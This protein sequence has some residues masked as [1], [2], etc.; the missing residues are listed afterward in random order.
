MQ[1]CSLCAPISVSCASAPGRTC[2]PLALCCCC[3]LQ[4]S[5]AGVVPQGRGCCSEGHQEQAH[6]SGLAWEAWQAAVGFRQESASDSTAVIHPL[7]TLAACKAPKRLFINHSQLNG[8]EGPQGTQ[9][10]TQLLLL[11]FCPLQAT[12]QHALCCFWYRLRL[13]DLEIVLLY[14]LTSPLLL[15]NAGFPLQVC[16]C[17]HC[18]GLP[19]LC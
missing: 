18:F 2:L 14:T 17:A 5:S 3:W 13:C 15:S 11:S 12:P 8:G 6:G 9:E 1:G 19:G 7:S 10:L 4:L 16:C